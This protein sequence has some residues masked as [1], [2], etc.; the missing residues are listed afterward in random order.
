[1]C[2]IFGT[3]SRKAKPFNKRAFCT[4]G[5]RN[6]SRGGDSCGVFIDGF[7]EYGVDKQKLFIDFF[8]DSVLLN[9]TTECKVAIGHC[10]KASVGK[11]SLETAQPVV[12]R[13]ENGEVDYVLIHNGTVYNYQELAK[14]YIPEIDITG[15]TDSQVMARIFYHAGYDAL[16][17]YQGGAVFVIHDYRINRT[18][19]FKGSS[20]KF[21]YSKE[22]EE[23]RPLYYCW[24]NGR[25]CFSSIFETLYAFYYEEV[26]Y[27]L[28]PNKLISI[29]DNKLKLVKEYKREKVG[30][31]KPTNAVVF[32][33][34]NKQRTIHGFDEWDDYADTTFC[35]NS[36]WKNFRIKYDGTRY[37]DNANTPL[38]GKYLMS[39]YGYVYPNRT[40]KDS[41]MHEVAFFDGKMLR[42]PDAFE[43]LS[44]KHVEA[45][46]VITKELELL[47]NM[48]DFNPYTYDQIQ[49]FWYDSDEGVMYPR[50][51][52]KIPMGDTSYIFDKEGYMIDMGSKPYTGWT[53]DYY[54]YTYE[55]TKILEAWKDLCA[56]G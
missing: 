16:D 12:L 30:Q 6:D 45:K 4:M 5:V 51:E 42:H 21:Q 47:I 27:T 50:G 35:P 9:N 54:M 20:K 48:L 31:F 49:Y 38:H 26:I 46:K 11:V 36:E 15:L 44:K 29:R 17:E 24:H 52:W 22:A 55:E 43:L 18:L 32:V 23:E 40:T 8:R 10:R 37:T 13:N 28:S 41:W 3:I 34:T 14:K 19:V 33:N 7:A 1:M 39:A 25:F 56:E 2:G 53:T